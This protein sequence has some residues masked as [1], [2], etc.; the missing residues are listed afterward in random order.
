MKYFFR[1]LFSTKAGAMSLVYWLVYAVIIIWQGFKTIASLVVDGEMQ[2]AYVF[3]LF[4][5]LVT[6][7]LCLITNNK[8]IISKK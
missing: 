4:A 7:F 3:Y 2:T 5:I 6:C 1:W 8:Y